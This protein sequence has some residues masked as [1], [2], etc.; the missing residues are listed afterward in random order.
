VAVD[1][2]VKD[3]PIERVS[4]DVLV[5]TEMNGEPLD[6]EHGFPAR[7]VVPGFYGTNSVKWL[8]RITLADVRADGPFTTRWY[9]DP[10]LD[11]EGRETGQ[12]SPV[13]QVAP[14]SVIVSPAPSARIPSGQVCELW[15]RAWGDK[16]IETVEISIDGGD[17]WSKASL[18]HRTGRSWQRF[19]FNWRPDQG[20]RRRLLSRAW[21]VSGEGQP[22]AGSRNAIYAVDVEVV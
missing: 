13:W 6:A 11:K 15:G 14:E 22:T 2:Y 5:A 12:T 8:T 3:L 4:D 19:A 16:P 1:Q 18:A 9:N 10:V 21:D 7:L 20:G 17:S